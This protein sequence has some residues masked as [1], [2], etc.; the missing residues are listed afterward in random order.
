MLGVGLYRAFGG[1]EGE[2]PARIIARMTL[3]GLVPGRGVR[4]RRWASGSSPRWAAASRSAAISI[5]AGLGL[6]AA[7]LLGGPRWL[8]LPAMVLV[9][10]LA[11]VSAADLDLRGGVGEHTYRPDVDGRRAPR[12]PARDGAAWTSTCATWSCPPGR[13][14]L[15]IRLGHGRGASCTRPAG[16][17]VATDARIGLGAADLP[18]RVD[19]GPDIDIDEHGAAQRRELVV[20]ARRRRRAPADR[21]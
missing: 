9:L 13:T 8:I 4:R 19:E 2:D 16:V 21:P 7:G 15:Q 17:C 5:V 10:P 11:V 3:V 18:N 12:V 20:N 14:E 1:R 6:I